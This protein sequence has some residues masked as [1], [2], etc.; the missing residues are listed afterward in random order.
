MRSF[1]SDFGGCPPVPLCA[2]PSA[3]AE[4]EAQLGCDFSF[5]F[6]KLGVVSWL[7]LDPT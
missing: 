3:L 5:A 6:K 4:S 1:R 7:L 2:E